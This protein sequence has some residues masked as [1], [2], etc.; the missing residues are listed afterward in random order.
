M[1]K[2]KFLILGL[3]A[4]LLAGGLVLVSCSNCPDKGGCSFSV[5]KDPLKAAAMKA[6][7]D[8]G[9]K[10]LEK[11]YTKEAEK[12]MQSQDPSKILGKSFSCDC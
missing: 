9:D 11:Q 7:S 12:A 6:P 4:L 1:K 2:G 5:P 3:I 10:C 8:C